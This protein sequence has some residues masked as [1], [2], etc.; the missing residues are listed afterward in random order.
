MDY[1]KM[2]NICFASV[3]SFD[4]FPAKIN[5]LIPDYIALWQQWGQ[6]VGN[7]IQSIPEIRIIIFLL[8]RV[9]QILMREFNE[10]IDIFQTWPIMSKA[11]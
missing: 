11:K 3:W 8:K 5:K 9:S 4:K 1:S 10:F 2:T 6:H 7:K